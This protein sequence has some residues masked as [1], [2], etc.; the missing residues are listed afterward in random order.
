MTR[1]AE[2]AELIEST[3]RLARVESERARREMASVLE[4]KNAEVDAFRCELDAILLDLRLMHAK[5]EEG[6]ALA[7]RAAAR[8]PRHAW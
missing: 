7:A 3:R 5:Q 4:A 2:A 8:R 1:E 6:A